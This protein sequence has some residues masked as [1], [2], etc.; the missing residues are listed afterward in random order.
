[1]RWRIVPAVSQVFFLQLR[2]R[3]LRVFSHRNADEPHHEHSKPEGQRCLNRK[4]RQASSLPNSRSKSSSE[5]RV[6]MW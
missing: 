5:R 6:L 2:H 4:S 3:R 1:V